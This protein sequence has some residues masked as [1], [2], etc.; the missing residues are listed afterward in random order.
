MNTSSCISK[1]LHTSLLLGSLVAL[2][3]TPVAS[4][5]QGC[6][7]GFHRTNGFCVKNNPGKWAT[8][9]SNN[10]WRNRWGQLRCR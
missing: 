6:G 4:A 10:C 9:V 2:S 7:Y 3:Y 5:A 8:P 1:V